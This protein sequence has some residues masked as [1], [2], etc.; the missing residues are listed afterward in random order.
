MNCCKKPLFSVIVPVYKVEN[1]LHQCVDSILAQTFSDFEVILV[2]D[3]S[4]DRCGA[5]CD[6]YARKDSRVKVIHQ[7]NG[8]ALNARW[9][10]YGVASGMYIVHVDSDD[11]ISPDLLA[12]VE[13]KIRLHGA[14]AVVFGYVHFDEHEQT[15]HPQPIDSGLYNENKIERFRA[16]LFVGADF[17]VSIHNNLWATVI[18]RE[19]LEANAAMTPKALY[20]GEDLATVVPALAQCDTVY[21][22]VECPYFYRITPG[23]IVNTHHGDELDQALL[24]AEYLLD[25]MGESYFQKTDIYVLRECASHLSHYR[26]DWREYGREARKMQKYSFRA[27]FRSEILGANTKIR[28]RVIFFLLRYRMFDLLWLIWW[29][30]RKTL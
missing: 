30:K 16:N 11:Y 17:D 8:G 12:M 10:G 23:S 1:Y 18:R 9:A 14:D 13:E 20:R 15:S 6:D 7:K 24:L 28:D 21:V 22:L 4:P 3:G 5:I 27:P 26:G 25:R 29:M 19:I 2:D